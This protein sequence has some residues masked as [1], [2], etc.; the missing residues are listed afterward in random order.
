MDVPPTI[1]NSLCCWAAAI[2]IHWP[3]D[4]ALT[5]DTVNVESNTTP[6]QAPAMPIETVKLLEN[7]PTNE[8]V[9]PFKR[10][11]AAG[12]LLMSYAIVRFSGVPRLK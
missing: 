5:L 10:A 11:F 1:R 2:E 7:M 6:Q 9:A 4:H 3:I 12:I 8:E